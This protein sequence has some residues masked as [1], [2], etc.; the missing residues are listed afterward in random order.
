MYIEHDSLRARARR[1]LCAAAMIASASGAYAMKPVVER[2]VDASALP[3][4]RGVVER[5]T[6]ARGTIVIYGVEYQYRASDAPLDAAAGSTSA[7]RPG[8][9]AKPLR[10]GM[11]VEYR[12]AADGERPRIVSISEVTP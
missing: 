10:A 12:V 5:V 1:A 8:A 2:A 3:A 9:T 4:L 6:P 11:S 7:G